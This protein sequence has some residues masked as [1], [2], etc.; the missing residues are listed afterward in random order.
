MPICRAFYWFASLFATVPVAGDAATRRNGLCD[1]LTCS[2]TPAQAGQAERRMMVPK[3]V[4]SVSEQKVLQI[5][6]FRG[7]K[8]GTKMRHDGA[9][10]GKALQIGLFGACQGRQEGAIMVPLGADDPGSAR[11]AETPT[12][13]AP[14]GSPRSA[15]GRHL[16]RHGAHGAQSKRRLA[17]SQTACYSNL[18]RAV[19][20]LQRAP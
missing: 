10:D 18:F 6:T 4:F 13:L 1:A 11:Q 19:V 17:C 16:G 14:F 2:E 5:G 3:G 9:R 7:A 20:G 8:R 12:P 15:R